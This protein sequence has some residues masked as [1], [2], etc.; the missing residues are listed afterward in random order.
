MAVLIEVD[1]QH[2]GESIGGELIGTSG[3]AGSDWLT[4]RSIPTTVGGKEEHGK[5][6][7]VGNVI[8]NFTI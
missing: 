7:G 4:K 2:D 6:R 1:S 8:G 5:Y 3:M